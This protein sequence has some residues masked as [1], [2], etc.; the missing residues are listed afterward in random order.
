MSF[1]CVCAIARL[2]STAHVTLPN[3]DSISEQAQCH[4]Q[5]AAR[6]IIACSYLLLTC[7]G[8]NIVRW[9]SVINCRISIIVFCT[10]SRKKTSI[11]TGLLAIW[12]VVV[13]QSPISIKALAR[14]TAKHAKKLQMAFYC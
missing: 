1:V 11:K 10:G 13:G 9:Q 14:Y 6:H 3:R 2:E 7:D 12:I 4:Y 8:N 5:H